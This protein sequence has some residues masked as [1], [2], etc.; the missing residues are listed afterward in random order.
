MRQKLEGLSAEMHRKQLKEV[1]QKHREEKFALKEEFEEQ[2]EEMKN[3][4][5]QNFLVMR[6]ELLQGRRKENLEKSFWPMVERFSWTRSVQCQSPCKL[7][8]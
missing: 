8:Y 2:L 3:F 5:K 7:N 1:R 6:E 4:W